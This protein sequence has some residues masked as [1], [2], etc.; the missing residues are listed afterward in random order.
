MKILESLF[1]YFRFGA[2]NVEWST[3]TAQNL[4]T[5]YLYFAVG[6]GVLIALCSDQTFN[7]FQI[8]GDR[9]QQTTVNP[10]KRFSKNLSNY[11]LMGLIYFYKIYIYKNYK[12]L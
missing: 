3:N 5:L 2:K 9:I 6:T 4:C 11:K 1:L 10:G 7:K 8:N 12:N